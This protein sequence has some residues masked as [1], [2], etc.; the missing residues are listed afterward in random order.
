MNTLIASVNISQQYAFGDLGSL[1]EGISR[2]TT[3]AFSIAAAL[4]VFYFIFGAFKYLA[5]GGN[6]EEL[7]KAQQM[8]T[9]A[10]IGFVLFMLLF[11]IVELLFGRLL[12][13][14]IQLIKG[15]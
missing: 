13:A 5:S 2:L 15:L 6:K 3:P 12:G 9:H 4:V 8:I 14:N 1:G 11:L 10:I 7:A